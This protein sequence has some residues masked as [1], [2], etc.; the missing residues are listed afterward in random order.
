MIS[1]SQI[2]QLKRCPRKYQYLY[3]DKLEEAPSLELNVGN[4]LHAGILNFLMTKDIEQAKEKMK[5]YYNKNIAIFL[6]EEEEGCEIMRNVNTILTK[7]KDWWDKQPESKLLD[8]YSYE[9]NII[10]KLEK[11]DIIGRIDFIGEMKNKMWVGELKTRSRIGDSYLDNLVLNSQSYLYQ[12]LYKKSF[13]S[14]NIGGVI[15]LIVRTNLSLK[16]PNFY[17]ETLYYSEPQVQSWLDDIIAM[18]HTL[19]EYRKR[20]YFPL[21]N[22]DY[23]CGSCSFRPLCLCS[24]EQGDIN[25]M[26]KNV[27]NRK[28]MKK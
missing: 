6:E 7:F 13:P 22:I 14:A 1:I 17:L 23:I 21:T 11:Y 15:F 10:S 18:I 3:E 4:L 2:N 26:K 24:I 27:Y 9:V 19:E 8:I 25:W 28:E 5:L 20:N 12:Y 16:L